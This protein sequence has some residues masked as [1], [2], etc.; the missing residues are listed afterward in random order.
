ML[1]R[2]NSIL[3]DDF[4]LF[5]DEQ[6]IEFDAA[7]PDLHITTGASGTGKTTLCSAI[8][9]A[10]FGEST[11]LTTTS[12]VSWPAHDEGNSIPTATIRID[13]DT[14][15]NR[16]R[17]ERTLTEK[18]TVSDSDVI[19][20]DPRVNLYH[21][22]TS[23]VDSAT[24][25]LSHLA[26]SNAAS[27]F[28]VD[29][30]ALAEAPATWWDNF[31]ERLLRASA[32]YQAVP[33]HSNLTPETMWEEFCAA[34]GEYVDEMGFSRQCEIEPAS[35]PFTFR[36]AGT[37]DE[38]PGTDLPI[39]SGPEAT[40]LALA[41]TLAAGDCAGVPQWFDAPIGCLDRDASG[42]A[43]DGLE[44]AAAQR[45]IVLLAHS[46]RSRRVPDIDRNAAT[47]HRL[48]MTDRSKTVVRRCD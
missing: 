44:A 36:T 41:M 2:I 16:Y 26:P 12:D 21:E 5:Q 20:S 37:R 30:D 24:D 25:T 9:I 13:F 4:R 42:R 23:A 31:A 10:L 22:R 17:V 32:A 1:S 11:R 15:D 29:A 46:S 35:T 38:T 34:L 33:G 45:Q 8:R 48:E 19:V 6:K 28:L 47:V 39:S 43:I 3:L 14:A 27:L 18:G 40:Q 7:S